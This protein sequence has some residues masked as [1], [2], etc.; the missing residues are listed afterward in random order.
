MLPGRP[1]L[2]E[3]RRPHGHRDRRPAQ[4]QG[5][6]QHP[7]AHRGEDARAQRDRRLQH[8]PRPAGAVRPVRREPRHG[9]LHPHRP[10]H[11]RHRRRRP[12]ALRAAPGRQRALAGRRV[13]KTARAG[14]NGQQPAVVWFTGLSGAGKSTIANIVEQK[15]HALGVHTYLLD[16]DNVRHGLN[17]DLGFTDADRVE[18]IR[19]VAEVARADGRRRARSCSC[20]SSRRS[21]P[22]GAWPATP[23]TTAS[24]SR[25]SSTRRS[26]SPRSATEGPLRQGPPR[27][28]DQLHRHRLALRSAREPRRSTSTPRSPAPRTPPTRSSSTLRTR[29][30]IA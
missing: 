8:Q 20:R 30:I 21:A 15:L 18:N 16:G 13:D 23:S 27:R 11:Q 10:V 4:V 3:D 24:S 7:R 29:R 1:Y 6:R 25:C 19:R 2:H 9:R 14:Q 12:A 26:R 28:A 17:H 22:S 5:Q